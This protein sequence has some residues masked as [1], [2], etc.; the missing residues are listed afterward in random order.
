MI[1]I[2]YSKDPYE[3]S[4]LEGTMEELSSL[5][6]KI[7]DFLMSDESMFFQKSSDYYDPYPYQERLTGLKIHKFD[8]KNVISVEG[9]YLCIKGDIFCLTNF[10]ENIPVNQEIDT[11]LHYDRVGR[12]EYVSENS[13]GLILSIR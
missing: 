5:A 2:R 13:F 3:E 10:I 12:E 9:V 1:E 6:T 7:K 8:H 11:H 4:E